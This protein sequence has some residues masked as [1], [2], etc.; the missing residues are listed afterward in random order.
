VYL[1]KTIWILVVLLGLLT[2]PDGAAQAESCG[3]MTKRLSRL[4][5]E[6]HHY[7]TNPQK[8]ADDF[9]FDGLVEI[10]DKIVDLKAEMQKSNCKIPPRPKGFQGK[11]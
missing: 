9:T 11:E 2:L 8:K 4:R 10:L 5:L 6:Y 1:T 3:Q 7:V